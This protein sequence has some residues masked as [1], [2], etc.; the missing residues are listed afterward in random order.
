VEFVVFSEDGTPI[1]IPIIADT[2]P[3]KA[4]DD[5]MVKAYATPHFS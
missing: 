5:K 1:E 4:I 3:I 2:S